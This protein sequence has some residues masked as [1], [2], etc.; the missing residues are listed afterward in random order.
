MQRQLDKMFSTYCKDYNPIFAVVDST[1]G[2]VKGLPHIYSHKDVLVSPYQS[3]G[4]G[5]GGK[6]F[7]SEKGGAYFSIVY[8]VKG[9][10][11][12]AALKYVLI[13]GL[14]VAKTLSELGVKDIHLK[15]PNDVYIGDK[16]V[17][18]ILLESIINLTDVEVIILGVGINIFNPP[19]LPMMISVR[20]IVQVPSLEYVIARTVKNIDNLIGLTTEELLVEYKH[21]C[22]TIGKIVTIKDSGKEGQVK[23]ITQEGYLIVNT[24]QGEIIVKSGEISIKE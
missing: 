16:K 11:P 13:A 10:L 21:K 5:R 23:D 17:S 4:R 14:G 2:A 15:W 7:L 12:E 9:I 6:S 3:E 18:G 20:D 22:S 8:K 24:P 1:N 19:K